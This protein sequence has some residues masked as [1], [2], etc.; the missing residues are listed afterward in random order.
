MGGVMIDLGELI[1]DLS[2]LG[3]YPPITPGG[4]GTVTNIGTG[5]GLTGGPI[6][7]TGVISLAPINSAYL[8][9]N[10]TGSSAAPLPAS[11]SAIIDYAIGDSQGD[12][13]Y[14]NATEWAILAPGVD[15]YF[16]QTG[17]VSANPTWAPADSFDPQDTIYFAVGGNDSNPG[18]PSLPLLT[19]GQAVTNAQAL[20]VGGAT[21]V[22]I[23]GLGTG[24]D[25]SNVSITQSGIDIYAPYWSLNPVSGDA[26]TVNLGS[27]GSL[28][29]IN[30]ILN[31]STVTSGA[32]ALNLISTSSN[33]GNV[34]NF[35]YL[36]PVTGDVYL[37]V[38]CTY[39]SSIVIGL[40]TALNAK[41]QA[42][43]Y[44]GFGSYSQATTLNLQ[45]VTA[46]AGGSYIHG[47]VN[48]TNLW[49]YPMRQI[50][51]LTG[52]LTLASAD[53][54]YLYINSTSST[55]TITL[56]DTTGQDYP[57]LVGY[58]ATFLNTS[59]GSI[60]FSP[61]GS[62]TLIGATSISTIG[63]RINCTLIATNTWEADQISENELAFFNYT[64]AL[65]VAQNNGNDSN[66]GLFEK[67]F[68]TVQHAINTSTTTPT[69]IYAVD[70]FSN[71]ETLATLGTG[72]SLSINAPATAFTGSLTT[73]SGDTAFSITA[74]ALANVANHIYATFNVGQ[75][76]I[77]GFADSAGCAITTNN[78]ISNY[79]TSSTIT[80]RLFCD[81]LTV[82]TI[83]TATA[84]YI[85]ANTVNNLNVESGATV[86]IICKKINTLTLQ[87]GAQ[88]FLNCNDYTGI[89]NDGTA[90]LNGVLNCTVPV[91]PYAP[92]TGISF[93]TSN[94][95]STVINN[96]GEIVPFFN[97]TNAFWVDPNGNDTNSGTN[98]DQPLQNLQTALN[99]VTAATPTIIHMPGAGTITYTSSLNVGTNNII[100][101][102]APGYVLQMT[103]SLP[104]FTGVYGTLVINC[105]ELI[106][107]SG[108][109]IVQF[110]SAAVAS[111]FLATISGI[112]QGNLTNNWFGTS[113]L[114]AKTLEV[115]GDISI[116]NSLGSTLIDC[117]GGTVIG[118]VTDTG[119]NGDGKGY[120]GLYA[121][122]IT[123]NVSSTNGRLYGDVQ[124]IG[125]TLAA[126]SVNNGI[127]NQALFTNFAPVLNSIYGQT[128]SGTSP[129]WTFTPTINF[130]GLQFVVDN[131]TGVITLPSGGFSLNG[132]NFSIIQA[133]AGGATI[134]ASGSDTL[135]VNGVGGLTTTTTAPGFISVV[136]GLSNGSGGIN[137]IISKESLPY[138]YTQA[139]WVSQNNGS[140]SN[141]GVSIEEPLLT[142]QAAITKTGNTR[143]KIYC[144]DYFQSSAAIA[145]TG[146]SQ[147]II[148][149][150][151]ST[152]FTGSF[153]VHNNDYVSIRAQTLENVTVASGQGAYMEAY[154]VSGYTQTSGAG[155]FIKAAKISGTFALSGGG[156][157]FL[158]CTDNAATITNDGT[159]Y[160]NG[161][162]GGTN[163]GLSG[164]YNISGT[165][166]FSTFDGTLNYTQTDAAP[167]A[168]GQVLVSTGA[169]AP[170][171]TAWQDQSGG[172]LSW[173]DVTSGTQ[174]MVANNGY[175]IDNG[176]SLVTLTLPATAAY[177]TLL[178]VI[179]VSAGGWSIAQNAGQNILVSGVS[180]TTGTGGSL[181]ST[182]P[183]DQVQLLCVVADT[184]WVAIAPAASLTYV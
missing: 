18:T 72:Q 84:I 60:A 65:W 14:R 47:P 160:L 53:S 174:A 102:D 148:I 109:D 67:P 122:S 87:T 79:T 81:L 137:W 17:G 61:S 155:T 165:L 23:Q 62:A 127:F 170:Y 31:S 13:L 117:T 145:T 134:N 150:A 74:Y 66:S 42:S 154:L 128:S 176:A 2:V 24:T 112:I 116:S 32:K 105:A 107:V 36:G 28:N 182:I 52:D 26:I 33:Q 180:T 132:W 99:D 143:A 136:A 6:T 129:S 151:T 85:S 73:T 39:Y 177:G 12:I 125:G 70:E 138:Q 43:T 97:Y 91:V 152:D 46:G 101:I 9:A 21:L 8:L 94:P 29:Y 71:S 163:P 69:I 19:L 45:G 168:S 113:I 58:E 144:V 40:L 55:Y 30:I 25:L 100:F 142:L 56:P 90:Y 34:V 82:S 183:S 147:H 96:T 161:V 37:S 51:Q 178:Q 131:A 114:Q 115:D 140:N 135:V 103:A 15:G 126:G 167:S 110:S 104:L 68:L 106:T 16:L 7:T 86:Y 141:S 124:I 153:T 159:V 164:N 146:S 64:N 93:D 184:T 173:T 92:G 83:S 77:N 35:Y 57:F 157:L 121:E 27:G 133:I 44:E 130:T 179:G 172:G 171:G 95:N 54:G 120:V 139:L 123:G 111:Q 162:L 63:Q 22:S 175:T 50:I 4:G 76:G 3:V 89:T 156:N 118:N 10:L 49:R 169:S 166:G 98:A 149:D 5:T 20:I 48:T 80:A 88:V 11:L 1:A 41:T 78:T 108:Q 38:R 181:S 59:T 119:S 75:G 158:S